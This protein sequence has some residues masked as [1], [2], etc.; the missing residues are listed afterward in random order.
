MSSMEQTLEGSK[1]PYTVGV[2]VHTGIGA[3][4]QALQKML[5]NMEQGLKQLQNDNIEAN[6]K[7][8]GLILQATERLAKLEEQIDEQRSRINHFYKAQAELDDFKRDCEQKAF[9]GFDQT[10]KEIF[11][12]LDH[13]EKKGV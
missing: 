4:Y 7:H 13:L 11:A 9:P 3:E 8:F 2:E 6:R 12:R 5:E 1:N 10:L